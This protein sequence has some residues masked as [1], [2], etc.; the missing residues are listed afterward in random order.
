V[1][2]AVFFE[3]NSPHVERITTSNVCAARIKTKHLFGV[4]IVNRYKPYS[5]SIKSFL[6]NSFLLTASFQKAERNKM[7]FFLVATA[8]GDF[9]FKEKKSQ[10]PYA[11][12]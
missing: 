3:P 7:S 9:F 4:L 11:C 5:F 6:S 1:G 8:T 2:F 10:L 12:A